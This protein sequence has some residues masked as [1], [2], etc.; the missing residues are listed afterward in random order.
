[1]LDAMEK[2]NMKQMLKQLIKASVK[3]LGYEVRKKNNVNSFDVQQRL[4]NGL[5]KSE[6]TIFD[7]GANKGQ[8]AKQYRS[9]FPNAEIYCFEPFPESVTVLRRT[10]SDDARIHIV[11]K[12]ISDTLGRATFYVNECDATNSLLP[13]PASTRRYYPEWAGP[14]NSIDAEVT[15][16]DK[17]IS[18]RKISAVDVLKLDIQGGELMAFHGA[19]NLLKAGGVQLVYTEI[20]FVPHYEESP[21]FHDLWSFLAGFGYSL[22]DIYNISRAR[23]GQ[24]RQGDAIFVSESLRHTVIDRY[25]D[26]P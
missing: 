25:P 24:I 3:G 21:L 26:E 18:D 16:L 19:R 5:R 23:N 20:M 7:V 2:G 15:T 14:K 10:F 17:I 4:M 13:R 1:M 8:S 22:F 11:P 9:R 6:I 12:A